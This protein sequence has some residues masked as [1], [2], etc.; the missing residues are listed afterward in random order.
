M[1]NR[2]IGS[3]PNLDESLE[4]N[5]SISETLNFLETVRSRRRDLLSGA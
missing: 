5:L 1:R 3:G 4:T 2:S